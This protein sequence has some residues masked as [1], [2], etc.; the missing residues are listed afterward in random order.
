MGAD[1]AAGEYGYDLP[2]FARMLQ[3]DAV[4]C[5][6]LDATRCGGFHEWLRAAA[7]A[8]AANVAVSAHTAPNLSAHVAAAT[9]N[10]RHL[11][12]FHD[13]DR[14]ERMFSTASST[15]LAAQCTRMSQPRAMA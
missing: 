2:Y 3:A 8:A 6:Q 1:V 13:H 12:W 4:D 15:R 10:I 11:E 9:P 14:I 5:L 7:A